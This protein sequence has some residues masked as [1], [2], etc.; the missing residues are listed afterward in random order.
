[1]EPYKNL[2]QDSGVIAY[3]PG[4][5]YIDVVFSD[6]AVYRYDYG[7]P[8]AEATENMKNLAAAGRGLN[9]Y[10]NQVVRSNYAEK[11]QGPD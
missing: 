7:N 6:G 9:T 8:G 11:L 10:I 2:G 4:P 5:D 3:E 1:M